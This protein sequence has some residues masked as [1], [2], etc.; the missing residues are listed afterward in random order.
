MLLKITHQTDLSYTDLIN[1]S[2]MEL[3]MTPRQEQDQHRLSFSLA[4]GPPAPV[5]SYFDWLG[6]TV[7][8]FS[9]NPFHSQIRIIA[10]SVVETS[11][12]RIAP[13]SFADRWPLPSDVWDY[14]QYD[15]LQFGGPV[16]D[17]PALRELADMIH[18]QPGIPLGELALRMLHLIN[19]QFTFKKGVTTVA[20]PITEI[21]EHKGGVCQDFTH[22]M[23]GLARAFKIPARYV[24]GLLHPDAQRFRG[25][26]QTHAWCE[27][28]FPSAG[29]VGFDA[30]NNCMI[31]ENFIK[32]AIGRDYR[33]V[34]PN[35]G[36]WRG[37]AQENIE[38]SV[39][40]D[41]LAAI[42]GELAA[43]RIEQLSIP[44][45]PD[46]SAA[47]RELIARQQ[48]HQQQQEQQQQ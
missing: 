9:V 48:E 47:H 15:Y 13:E 19:E 43:E 4:L 33:D 41:T 32:T 8:A 2:V 5:N 39:Q 28:L 30:A 45:F 27:L 24:S 20:S 1:E 17:C 31:G 38:V 23:I 35:K 46:G 37:S 16:S 40:T 42:P 29:W 12:P 6:N 7:H 25:F 22:L 21:L 14:S 3:R 44:I 10:T 18:P 36:T 34:P 11:R 26:T